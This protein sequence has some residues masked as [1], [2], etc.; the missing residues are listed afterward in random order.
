[1]AINYATPDGLQLADLI[2]TTSPSPTPPQIEPPRSV[3]PE[4]LTEADVAH[5][6][7]RAAELGLKSR[8]SGNITETER[9]LLAMVK[10]AHLR[11]TLSSIL[12][13]VRRLTESA[14][15]DP[16]QLVHQA[17][18]ISG[19]SSQRDFLV[20]QAEEERERWASQR[21]GWE[22]MAEALIAQRHKTTNL[23][24][25]DSVRVLDAFN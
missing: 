15:L 2:H 12:N 22:R 18:M 3:S 19:L 25:K 17:E 1:M 4:H 13:Q 10:W 14:L 8:E 7:H 5:I 9:E 24:S 16:S 21:D 20:R 6:R 23:G 11:G